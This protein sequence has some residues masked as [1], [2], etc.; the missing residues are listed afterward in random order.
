MPKTPAGI[1]RSASSSNR[2]GSTDDSSPIATPVARIP[3]RASA[4]RAA[5]TAAGVTASAATPM[6]IT[7]PDEPLNRR[8]VAALSKM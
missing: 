7:S 2:Y 3:G 4:P 5:T 6:A 8:P 1:R